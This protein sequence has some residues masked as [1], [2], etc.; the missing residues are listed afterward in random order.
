MLHAPTS[1]NPVRAKRPVNGTLTQIDPETNRPAE[2][3]IEVGRQPRDIDAGEGALWVTNRDGNVRRIDNGLRRRSDA[4][5]VAGGVLRGIVVRPRAIW[6]ANATGGTIAQIDPADNAL[7]GDEIE[8]GGPPMGSRSP[9]T[10]S[11]WATPTGR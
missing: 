11:G 9:P 6:L 10:P 3:R 8:V 7:R 5:I 1:G 4:P 2:K